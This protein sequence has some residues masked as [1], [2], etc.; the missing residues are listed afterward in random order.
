MIWKF[1]KRPLVIEA[2]QFTGDNEAEVKEFTNGV[3]YRKIPDLTDTPL[4]KNREMLKAEAAK[5]PG[6]L[7][8]WEG[9][10]DVHIGAWVIKG[11]KGEFYSRVPDGG[12]EPY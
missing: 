8:T 11:I 2:V 7:R 5:M 10:F 9:V 12:I 4:L 3:F 6:V 1:R